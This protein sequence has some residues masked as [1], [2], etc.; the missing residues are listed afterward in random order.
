M[1]TGRWTNM[2][3]P[4]HAFSQQ[5]TADALISDYHRLTDFIP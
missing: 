2:A 5:F 3:K 4:I 1:Q